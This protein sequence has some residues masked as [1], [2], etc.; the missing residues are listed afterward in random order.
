MKKPKQEKPLEMCASDL[1][2]FARF[3]R[4][5]TPANA[6]GVDSDLHEIKALK[7]WS[8]Q[9]L[10]RFGTTVIQEFM[11]KDKAAAKKALEVAKRLASNG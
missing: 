4:L 1:A 9:L 3:E 8:V 5:I 6:G 2:E 11:F 7:H 10:D